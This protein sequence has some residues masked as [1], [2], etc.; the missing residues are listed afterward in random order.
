MKVVLF[1]K[2]DATFTS[3]NYTFIHKIAFF[4]AIL[5]AYPWKL[6]AS[7]ASFCY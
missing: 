5:P 1:A 7:I 2:R 3:V 4:S 6:G